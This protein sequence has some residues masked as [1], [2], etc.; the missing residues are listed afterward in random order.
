M[1]DLVVSLPSILSDFPVF[2]L[3]LMSIS[4]ID[5]QIRWIQ[6]GRKKNKFFFVD[7]SPNTEKKNNH[8]N[9]MMKKRPICN[10]HIPVLR[11]GYNIR[12]C[13]SSFELIGQS[14][15]SQDINFIQSF[16]SSHLVCDMFAFHLLVFC[17]GALF[18]CPFYC[19]D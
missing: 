8:Y 6:K 14:N 10:Q 2:L 12:C 9:L 13:K 19:F 16:S 11:N 7:S 3:L 15:V 1:C 17:S 5:S 4:C 18:I